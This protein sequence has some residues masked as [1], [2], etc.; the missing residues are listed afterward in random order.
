[1]YFKCVLTRVN[2]YHIAPVIIEQDINR[3]ENRRIAEKKMKLEQRRNVAGGWETE[4]MNNK[5]TIV[6]QQQAT[7][8]STMKIYVHLSSVSS[9]IS[10]G[11]TDWQ[12]Q[13]G[14]L[15]LGNIIRYNIKLL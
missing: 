4:K 6:Q 2:D 14:E 9:A 13:P 3:D 10:L 7:V 11:T 15:H 1:M 12:H 8:Q 5:V